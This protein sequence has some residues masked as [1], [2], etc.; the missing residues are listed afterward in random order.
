MTYTQ[1]PPLRQKKIWPWLVGGLVLA[2][3]MGMVALCAGL[4]AMDGT[5]TPPPTLPTTTLPTTEAPTASKAGAIVTI[6]QGDWLVGK[7]VAAG[8]YRTPGAEDS[9]VPLCNWAVWTDDYKNN[10]VA[11]G[12]SSK[13]DQPGRVVLKA[14]QVFETSGCKP[15][16]KQ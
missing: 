6:G 12:L 7:E 16:V 9:A 14:G 1:Q 15:W 4:V 8:T 5:V 2:I 3:L 13:V 11:V 10:A